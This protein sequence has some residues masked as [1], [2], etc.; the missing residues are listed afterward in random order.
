[1]QVL[2]SRFAATEDSIKKEK[3]K[4]ANHLYFLYWSRTTALTQSWTKNEN[5]SDITD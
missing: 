1:M 2:I 3:K 4:K 5:G